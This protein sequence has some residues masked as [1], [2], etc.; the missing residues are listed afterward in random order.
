MPRDHVDRILE[1]W[2]HERPDLD[3]SPIGVI[4]RISRAAR[5]LERELE[6][7]YRRHGLDGGTYDVLATLRRQGAP[8]T[9]SAS[10][11]ADATMLARSS[12]TSRVDRLEAAGLV[13]RAPDEHDGR[14]VRVTLS[15]RGLQLIDAATTD[16]LANEAR[17]LAGLPDGAGARLADD[18]RALLETLE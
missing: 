8:Y 11:L 17:L 1:Q 13:G 9:L 15:A 12:M 14:G 3:P 5:Y 2:A 16:H 18:L 10:A 6:T 4:G 7:A